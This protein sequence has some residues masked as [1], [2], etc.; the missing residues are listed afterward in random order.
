MCA[1][2]GFLKNSETMFC[3]ENILRA[4]GEVLKHRGPDD[5]GFF[6]DLNVG[7]GMQRLSILD[8][9]GGHQPMA[10]ED[11]KVWVVFNGEIYNYLE[12]KET[13]K[14]KGHQFKSSSDTEVIV[15]AYEEYG[16]DF[17]VHLRGMFACAVWDQNHRNLYLVRDRLGIK[18]LFY[19]ETSE[20]MAFAS[21]AKA[22]FVVP[23]VP[24][25]LN[26]ALLPVLFHLQYVPGPGTLFKG[27]QKLMPGQVLKWHGGQ[28]TLKRYWDLPK[29]APVP[30]DPLTLEQAG[31]KLRELLKESVTQHLQSDVPLG[32]FLSG[33]LDSSAMVAL[34]TQE[35]EHPVRTFTVG[36][37]GPKHFNELEYARE[38]AKELHTD[39]TEI[40]IAPDE[41]A[42]LFDETTWYLDDLI[43]DPAVLPTYLMSRLARQSVTVALSGEG[44]DELFGGYLRY[45]LDQLAPWVQRVP[46]AGIT[47]GLARTLGHLPFMRRVSQGLAALSAGKAGDRHLGWV[48]ALNPAEQQGLFGGAIQ[49]QMQKGFLDKVFEAYFDQTEGQDSLD[50]M[51]RADLKT[52]LPDDLLVKVDRMSMAVSLEARVPYLDHNL[53]EFVL[54]LPTDLKVRGW[55]S[56]VVLKQ[57][58]QGLVPDAILNRKKH[59][60]EL[61]LAQWFR[62]ELKDFA[63]GILFSDTFRKRK[64]FNQPFVDKMWLDH[65]EGREDR[66][67]VLF[68][69][70]T[71]ELWHRIYL[72]S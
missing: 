37:E 19:T 5:N 51:Q 61:P 66:S 2:F 34:M 10:S 30:K 17:P 46:G 57:A 48:A 53:V 1:I 55:N 33:G 26:L 54:G 50:R 24:R 15:H 11:H 72:D 14:A 27:I 28:I 59:G 4:M 70:I 42:K 35:T 63:R 3:P 13:L 52:W 64:Y 44:G 23:L 12:L 9:Q 40:M 67:F 29:A 38:A 36:F 39:H 68:S 47:Q 62:G 20:G 22:L 58:C 25:E 7:I 31:Q 60:F 71:F 45:R 43:L 65:Q 49:E 41:I 16:E 18:P 69:L 21:E 32:A 6:V 56:K 8:V